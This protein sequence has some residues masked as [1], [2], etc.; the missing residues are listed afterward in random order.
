M[1]R[2]PSLATHACDSGSV[3][4]HPWARAQ[5]CRGRLA[6]HLAGDLGHPLLPVAARVPGSAPPGPQRSRHHWRRGPPEEGGGVICNQACVGGGG[7]AAAV[8]SRVAVVSCVA[9]SCGAVGGQGVGCRTGAG[10][11][12]I[13][14]VEP[15]VWSHAYVAQLLPSAPHEL[16]DAA[17][18]LRPKGAAAIPIL[19]FGA[20]ERRRSRLGGVRYSLSRHGAHAGHDAAGHGRLQ[21]PRP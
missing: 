4:L 9:I 11:G 19:P 17:D 7:G 1:R 12:R 15:H 3:T 10:S 14:P 18:E 2:D 6:R 13:G 16:W 20:A 21:Q 8:V 5:D